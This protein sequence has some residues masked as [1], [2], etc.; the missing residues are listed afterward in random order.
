VSR[1]LDN[2]RLLGSEF[3]MTRYLVLQVGACVIVAMCAACNGSGSDSAGPSATTEPVVDTPEHP[4]K[5]VGDKAPHKRPPRKLPQ[6]KAIE[7]ALPAPPDVSGP[8]ADAEKT[9][10]GLA[11]R[12]LKKGRGGKGPGPY[13]AVKVHYTGWTT[14]GINFDSSVVRGEPSEFRLNQVIKGWTEGLQLMRVGEKRR[15]WIP[16]ELAYKGRPGRPQGMLV[17]DVQ[18]L[19]ITRAPPLPPV[20]DDVSG[21]PADA[22]K[23]ASGLASK[24]LEAGRGEKQPGPDSTVRVNY[25]GW[26][27]DGNLFR[28][29]KFDGRPQDMPLNNISSK[30]L[31]EGIQLMVEGESRRLWIPEELAYKG[32]PGGPEGMVVIDV[33]LLKILN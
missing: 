14:D 2:T 21:P 16:E 1:G 23:T 19:G 10:S 11:S 29:T 5:A 18:L 30:G 13:D 24:V 17:F 33:E 20:P 27:T 9:P 8:P 25:T 28:S 26:T 7:G 22:E 31:S 15:F 32:R 6:V 4:A 3:G 12:L